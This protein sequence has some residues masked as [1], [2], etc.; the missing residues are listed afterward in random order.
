MDCREENLISRLVSLALT[1]TTSLGK[2]HKVVHIHFLNDLPELGVLDTGPIITI[3]RSRNP[4]W[5][6][7]YRESRLHLFILYI[8]TFFG[9]SLGKK[10]LASVRFSHFT[11]Y[12]T[13]MIKRSR[14]N[15]DLDIHCSRVQTSITH[16]VLADIRHLSKML[17]L[18]F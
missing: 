2:Q 12:L 1:Q 7:F 15:N 14:S 13:K 9:L 6:E 8:P 5:N 10:I 17:S 4:Q 16:L 3:A 18:N 11:G